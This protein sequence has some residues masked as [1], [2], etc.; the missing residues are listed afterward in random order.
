MTPVT[1]TWSRIAVLSVPPRPA[2]VGII[3]NPASGRDIRRLTSRAS[4][5]PNAEK[6]S[7]MVRA[8]AGLEA[9]GVRDVMIMP[10]SG[11]ICGPLFRALSVTTGSPVTVKPRFIDMPVTGSADDTLRATELMCQAGAG[12][13]IVLGGDG[14]HRAVAARCGQVPL[15]ALSTGTNNAF[16]EMREATVAG[17]AAGLLA[18]GAVPAEVAVRRNKLLRVRCDDRTDIALVDLCVTRHN[19]VGSRAV[20]DSALLE[21]L[22]VAFAGAD[23]IGLS[24]IAGQLEPV[25]RSA[26]H[27]LHVRCADTTHTP[28]QVIVPIAPGLISA[29]GIRDYAR[30]LPGQPVELAPQ[31]G[32]I[33]LDGEREIE[34]DPSNRISV[35]LDLHGPLTID[36]AAV[37]ENA[38]RRRVL[39]HYAGCPA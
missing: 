7:M 13:I 1:N 14:T 28:Q 24:A 39:R 34:F 25:T 38:A 30:L 20:W 35:E 11:G 37:L 32:T 9:A 26:P 16:P 18:T 4:V 19:Y 2:L 10:D 3:A 17:L 27:G 29:V 5:F 8:I 15:L 36:V 33:A 22:F 6:A 31:S 23:A 12:A 21:E